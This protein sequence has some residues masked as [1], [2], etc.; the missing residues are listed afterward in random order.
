[1]KAI[2]RE[3]LDKAEADLRPAEWELLA[4][5]PNY[6][7]SAFHAQ[8]SAEKNLKARL[9]EAEV[10]FPK[11][12]DLAAILDLLMPLEPTWNRLR[13]DLDALTSLGIEVRYPGMKADLEDAE[14][15]IRTATE[16]NELVRAALE[17]TS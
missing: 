15:A 7:A 8:Q 6:D 13:R 4:D 10:A 14:Q 1:M 3:W 16:L 17:P 11:T 2:T 9:V 5:P 12:H